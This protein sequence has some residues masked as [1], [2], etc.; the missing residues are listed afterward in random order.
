MDDKNQINLGIDDF[1]EM[2]CKIDVYKYKN[3]FSKKDLFLGNEDFSQYFSIKKEIVPSI[4]E[5]IIILFL[6]S[7]F[8]L[9]EWWEKNSISPNIEW[10]NYL[11]RIWIPEHFCIKE[12]GLIKFTKIT[13]KYFRINNIIGIDGNNNLINEV[14]LDNINIFALENNSWNDYQYIL[15]NKNE[16]ILFDSWTTA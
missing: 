8:D 4:K 3:T 7:L 12:N 10:K 5:A 2:A 11:K 6:I 16:Y 14:L 13:E 1:A 9:N 15:E